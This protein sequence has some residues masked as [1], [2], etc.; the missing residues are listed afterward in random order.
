MPY[1]SEEQKQK[2]QWAKEQC[3]AGGFDGQ[4]THSIG[5]RLQ[6]AGLESNA[7][8]TFAKWFIEKGMREGW[9]DV[10]LGLA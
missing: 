1:L 7:R 2:L 3:E 10:E 4:D 5:R 6:E 9:L 8:Q